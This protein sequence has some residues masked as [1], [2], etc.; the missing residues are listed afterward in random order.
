MS[1]F[2]KAFENYVPKI[3]RIVLPPNKF[4]KAWDDFNKKRKSKKHGR[5]PI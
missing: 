4:A 5:K 2:Q 1:K 3:D